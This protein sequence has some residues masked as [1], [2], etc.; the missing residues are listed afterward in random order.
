[1]GEMVKII[2]SEG[3][4]FEWRVGVYLGIV[5]MIF[6]KKFYNRFKEYM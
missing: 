2:E 1:M 3:L 5:K 6:V 4:F